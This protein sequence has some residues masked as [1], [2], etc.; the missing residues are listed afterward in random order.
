MRNKDNRNL[1]YWNDVRMLIYVN[2]ITIIMLK[3]I[4]KT[5]DEF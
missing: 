5:K 3:K 2:E 1:N 4:Q